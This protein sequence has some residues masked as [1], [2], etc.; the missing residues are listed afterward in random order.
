VKLALF[1]AFDP[2]YPRTAVLLEAL[3]ARGVEVVR[4]AARQ[5]SAPVAREIQ[6]FTRWAARARGLRTILVP[7]F[8][9]RDVPLASLLGRRTGVPVLFDPL[10]SRW[11]TQVTDLGRVRPGS[12]AAARLRLSDRLALSLADLVLCDTWEQGDFYSAR[13]GV[14]RPRLARIPVGADAETFRAGAARNPARPRGPAEIVY[15]GGYL[16]LH[17]MPTVVDAMSILEERHGTRLA[18]FTL[19]GG[20]MLRPY[21][22][23]EVAA[24]GLRSVRLLPRVAYR[25]AVR[26]MSEADIALGVFGTTEKAARVVPHKVWQALALGLPVVTRRS[27]AVSEFFRDGVHLRCVPPGDG[28]SL[29]RVLEELAADPDCR[30]RLGEA[31]RSEAETQGGPR[32]IGALLLEAIER[33]LELTAPRP[34]RGRRG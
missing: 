6:L 18:R 31:G 1:G 7:A 9:H 2:E 27:A 10:V 17:G 19:V 21:V 33:S 20:G 4:V 11:D 28:V 24:R 32:L 15:V 12:L 25:E 5:G 26:Q 14:P 29:A 22:E 23:R 13:Y 34:G 30:M 3:T 16:P 8:G